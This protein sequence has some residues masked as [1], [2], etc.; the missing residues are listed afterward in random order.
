[1]ST[2]N[3]PTSPSLNE[4]YSFGTKTWIWN[5]AA[6]QL[7]TA[8]AINDI[9]IGNVTPSTGA[10][11]TVSATGNITADYFIGNGSQL[12]GLPESYSNANV[13]AYLPTYTG[14]LV[15]L[16]GAVT[17]TANISG[18]YFI[19]N[20]SQ[21]TGIQTVSSELVNG[22]KT[23]GLNSDGTVDMPSTAV[24]FDAA[25]EYITANV[26]VLD[27]FDKTQYQTAKYLVQAATAAEV[28]STELLLTHNSTATF[29]TQYATLI[30]S[31][32]L[33]TLDSEIVNGNVVLSVTTLNS[34]TKVDFFRIA[35]LATTVI[36]SCG[37]EG[38]LELQSGTVDLNE[39]FCVEDLN[40]PSLSCGIEG[41][42]ELQSG[43]VNLGE[44]FCVEDLNTN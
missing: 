17:T 21:L 7:S 27:Q 34:D 10:F 26:H 33:I 41:D 2:L 5:G 24:F 43:T 11:T 1:M 4:T 14:N 20:G 12:T 40:E 8:G 42:L 36:P 29:M 19:G 25:D 15:S 22:S 23:F 9:P 32:A 28:H 16:T 6:W 35:L 13:A 38:D 39:G 3:F 31:N 37:I 44:G 30:S 18:N